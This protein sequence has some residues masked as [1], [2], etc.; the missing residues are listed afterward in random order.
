MKACKQKKIEFLILVALFIGYAGFFKYQDN[1]FINSNNFDNDDKN[2][3]TSGSWVLTYLVIDELGNGN[4]TW[5]EAIA[6]DWCTYTN[7]VYIIENV[8]INGQNLGYGAC[9]EIKNSVVQFSIKNCTLS[10]PGSS[11]ACIKL[12]NVTNGRI[13]NN[14]CRYSPYG[15]F[16]NNSVSVNVV[17]NIFSY[18]NSRGFYLV[19]SNQ[20]NF[21]DNIIK[22]GGFGGY[23]DDSNNNQFIDNYISDCNQGYY[24][25][26]SRDNDI[27]Y[28]TIVNC[29]YNGIFMN[30][31]HDNEISN[32]NI[33]CN[34]QYGIQIS[35]S[36]EFSVVGNEISYNGNDG[37]YDGIYMNNCD[38]NTISD[39]DINNNTQNG[40]RMLYCE[41][42]TIDR[43]TISLNE[44]CGVDLNPYS[45]RN[46]FYRNFFIDN[47]IN[48]RDN[49]TDNKW[50]YN[51][52]GNYWSDYQG[53]DKN[54]DGIGDTPYNISGL[55]N[56]TDNFPIWNDG[57]EFN[58]WNLLT[59]VIVIGSITLI[60][61]VVVIIYRKKNL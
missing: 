11:L 14:T 19:N 46:T 35:S 5:S 1:L 52:V 22:N 15:I 28:N 27:Y 13:E 53:Y 34:E 48:A 51:G 4:Y 29:N 18:C 58:I 16:L 23:I 41:D 59:P 33:S 20:S 37:S 30:A 21:S 61:V 39:N 8:T 6:Q 45:D 31:G 32:N 56:S 50:D 25:L 26:S 3:R 17:D 43:N 42:N 60:G 55:V 7:G 36:N 10:Y 38:N 12:E 9:I 40:I 47:K 54:D 2:I 44:E 49:G 24:L 57:L